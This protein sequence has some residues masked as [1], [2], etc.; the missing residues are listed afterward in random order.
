MLL[1][2]IVKFYKRYEQVQKIVFQ[3]S[4]VLEELRRMQRKKHNNM[5]A[6]FIQDVDG[7][8]Q[9]VRGPK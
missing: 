9:G 6:E 1:V 5:V 8:S 2:Y 7:A 4:H 3:N